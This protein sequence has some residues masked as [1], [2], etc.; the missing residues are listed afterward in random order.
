MEMIRRISLALLMLGSVLMTGCASIVNGTSQPLTVVAKTPDNRDLSGATCKLTSSK[1]EWYAT[2]PG[3]VVVHRGYGDMTVACDH[4]AYTGTSVVKS[5]T[6]GMAFGN[7][8][9][10]GIIGVAVDAGNGS[11]YDY[12]DLITVSMSSIVATDAAP[13]PVVVAS[14]PLIAVG[15]NLPPPSPP[16]SRKPDEGLPGGKDG[17]QAE[18]VAQ[19]QA[20]NRVP[21]ALL[22]EKGPGFETY[23]IAC[24][25]GSPLVV[26]CEFGNCRAL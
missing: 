5:T 7:I 24:T 15:G 13:V 11:A 8:L 20:C 22:T 16:P 26:R 23:S 19:A 2:T 25:S 6:K 18:R 10:G 4:P 12:P 9:F 17:F 3:S 14:P 21:I 1:G